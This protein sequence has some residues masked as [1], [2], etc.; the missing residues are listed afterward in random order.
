[1]GALLE[2]RLEFPICPILPCK[3]GQAVQLRDL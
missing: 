2:V 1:M 3:W